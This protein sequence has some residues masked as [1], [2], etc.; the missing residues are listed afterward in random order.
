MGSVRPPRPLQA[1]PDHAI[2]TSLTTILGL[3]E[4][5]QFEL[6]GPLGNR[7]KEYA[8]DICA[9]AAE[10]QN[11]IRRSQ[12]VVP[13]AK[14]ARL[15][16]LE[17]NA[18]MLR[19]GA[20]SAE[21]ATSVRRPD[22]LENREHA[23]ADLIGS[24]YEGGSDPERWPH[25]LKE[26][27][28]LLS[29]E[30][31]SLLL[32][33]RQ[34]DE[35]RPLH[36]SSVDD[37]RDRALFPNRAAIDE[38][39]IKGRMFAPP[40]SVWTDIAIVPRKIPRREN[41]DKGQE[42]KDRPHF[43]HTLRGLIERNDAEVAYISVLRRD[44]AGRFGNDETVLLER[45]MPHLHKAMKIYRRISE[46]KCEHE[47]LVGTFDRFPLAIALVQSPARL[48]CFNR[49]AKELLEAADGLTL[50]QDGLCAATSQET[51]ALR[52][53][54]ANAL[55]GAARQS[56]DG[57]GAVS[58]SR[59]SGR[60]PLSVLVLPIPTKGGTRGVHAP[61]AALFVADPEF[62][63]KANDSDLRKFWQLTKNEA[64]VASLIAQGQNVE[65]IAKEMGIM[66]NTIR[67]H[68]KHIFDKTQTEG[69]VE[70]GYL[71]MTSPASL[72]RD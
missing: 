10:L 43:L 69:Q 63:H 55:A 24:A 3:S 68:L 16:R 67:T 38:S 20:L 65:S 60:K 7:Y 52:E 51:G 1:T 46:L 39:V 48:V 71:I 2:R 62:R 41:R 59:P 61:V 30:C 45:I 17:R 29:A 33:D 19:A 32:H 42:S 6:F 58:I 15:T 70:L 31:A 18:A 53:A 22:R 5:L 36:M 27:R 49:R 28:V 56:C 37:S 25:F 9:S 57:T 8:A 72:R 23:F 21:R 66:P 47:G 11:L 4:I 13:S 44:T 54:I 50:G 64:R 26:L 40:G 34:S 12:L 14:E 35:C